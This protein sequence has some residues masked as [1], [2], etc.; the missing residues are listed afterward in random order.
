MTTL[1]TDT[2]EMVL[3]T[4]HEYAERKLKPEYLRQ[5]D[6]H[7]EFPQLVLE[8]LYNPDQF[9]LHLLFIPEE[10]GGLGGGAY[11]IYRVSEL[12]ARIDL[13]I[14]TGV[15]ATFLGSDPISVGGTE[16]QKARWMG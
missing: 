6:E 4:L 15:L 13:G 3:S 12:M 1:D 7:D 8:D 10:Y 2:L 5:L 11:D 14:A 16:E 9:G